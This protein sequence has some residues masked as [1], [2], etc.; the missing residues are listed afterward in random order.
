[1]GAPDFLC[2]GAQKAGTT[3]L[4]KNMNRHP[5]T[6]KPFIKEI[7]YFDSRENPRA[8][9]FWQRHHRA[10][11]EEQLESAVRREKPALAAICRKLIAGDPEILSESWY[12]IVF[13]AKPRGKVAGDYTP[14]YSTL[15]DD[16]VERI[17]RFAPEAK[18]IYLIRE[19]V[20]RAVSQWRMRAQKMVDLPDAERA[21]EAYT[22]AFIENRM[23]VGGDYREFVPRWMR[24]FGR[25]R[26]L[27]LPF[28][29]IRTR[30]GEVLGAVE[31]FLGV[32]ERAEHPLAEERFNGSKRVEAPAY[33]IRHLEADLRP[34]REFL[35]DAFGGDFNRRC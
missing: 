32:A 14:R 15:P 26:I 10:K 9:Q 22:R 19:P 3:W 21:I 8:L 31:R 13:E 6:W 30:P 25:D 2:I 27:F 23:Y 33:L 17:K 20:S 24:L 16:G 4:F 5:Q 7:H 29:D 28:G 11:L 12:R 34:H 18:I 1:M 35:A